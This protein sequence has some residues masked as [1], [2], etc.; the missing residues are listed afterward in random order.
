MPQFAASLQ[1]RRAASG[2]TIWLRSSVEHPGKPANDPELAAARA[3]VE[4]RHAIVVQRQRY[5]AARTEATRRHE[6]MIPAEARRADGSVDTSHPGYRKARA[7]WEKELMQIAAQHNAGYQQRIADHA[8]ALEAAGAH[9]AAA[10]LRAQITG[11]PPRKRAQSGAE[12]T[13]PAACR[14]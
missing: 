9:N 5:D 13:C 8:D 3:E 11:Q 12:P 6:A 4:K 10:E 1:D 2:P 14:N 7:A